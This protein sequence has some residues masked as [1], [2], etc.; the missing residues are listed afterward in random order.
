MSQ[1]SSQQPS[2]PPPGQPVS[3]KITFT[4]RYPHPNQ[5]ANCSSSILATNN[6]AYC[7]AHQ[8]YIILE[9]ASPSHCVLP[10]N[11]VLKNKG[12]A[13]L[14]LYGGSQH[15]LNTILEALSDMSPYTPNQIIERHITQHMTCL[16]PCSQLC[17][18]EQVRMNVKTDKVKTYKKFNKNVL[19]NNTSG[20]R[21]VIIQLQSFAS[22]GV[23]MNMSRSV[24]LTWIQVYGQMRDWQ[25]TTIGSAAAVDLTADSDM[26][27][28]D[29]ENAT[30]H[31]SI[32]AK[33]PRIDFAAQ[34]PEKAAFNHGANQLKE[35]RKHVTLMEKDLNRAA[36]ASAVMA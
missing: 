1:S 18:A 7:S 22:R 26:P 4:V 2:P 27:A 34:S 10:T 32:L 14:S 13:F 23:H 15:D 9:V 11:I 35:Y 36:N 29:K 21:C 28:I 16:I 20:Y 3:T 12:T 25:P 31:S 17:S 30:P 19:L 6:N 33:R 5:S 24:G 8:Q